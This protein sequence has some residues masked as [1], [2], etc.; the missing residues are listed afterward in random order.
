[1]ACTHNHNPL[2]FN[3]PGWKCSSGGT[4]FHLRANECVITMLLLT[5]LVYRCNYSEQSGVQEG[6]LHFRKGNMIILLVG[7]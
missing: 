1:M 4:F 5:I 7:L 2:L 3:V 6:G